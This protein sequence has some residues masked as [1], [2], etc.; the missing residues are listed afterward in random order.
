MIKRLLL[1]IIIL[2]VAAWG[3]LKL[4]GDAGFIMIST[5]GW[6]FEM[7][8]WFGIVSLASLLLVTHLTGALWR[9]IR[10]VKQQWR[11]WR[12]K[13][14]QKNQEQQSLQGFLAL[15]EGNWAT[16]ERAL[17]RAAKHSPFSH[18]LGAAHAAFA[19]HSPERA[20]DYLVAAKT[21]TPGSDLAVALSQAHL[22]VMQQQWPQAR[23]LVEN[24]RAEQPQHP[25]VIHL[26][27]TIYLGQQD[28][29]AFAD[30]LP[31][32]KRRHLIANPTELAEM[33]IKAY[34]A[35]LQQAAQHDLEEL[36]KTWF[37]LPSALQH[38]SQLIHAYV[39]SLVHCQADEYAM[40]TI[41][42]ILK[43]QWDN[44]LVSYYST[45]KT[46]PEKLLQHAKKWLK[47]H[48]H[49]AALLLCLGRLAARCE[50]WQDALTYLQ[51]ARQGQPSAL[52]DY[53]LGLTYQH[54]G[55]QQEAQLYY[56]QAAESFL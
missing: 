40:E 54:L 37:D 31:E 32:I 1:I 46:D 20:Q 56:R 5:L 2:S 53:Y 36:Q 11:D 43:K 23:T 8:L 22:L 18:Y 45:L 49:N 39:S 35:A 47:T 27:K 51:Q 12:S 7:P 29:S 13:R 52:C 15:A 33:E 48:A 38:E 6:R 41:E 55:Q 17:V 24:L 10:C 14:Q 19:Q 30:L 34:R 9:R 25:Q 42:R 16:A 44:T 21:H 3:V 4:Q 26:L 50:Q 28:W